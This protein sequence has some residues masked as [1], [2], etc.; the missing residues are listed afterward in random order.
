MLSKINFVIR[1]FQAV[2]TCQI[3]VVSKGPLKENRV[4][5][6]S[7]MCFVLQVAL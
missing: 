5:M 1:M 4:F 2:K 7:M 6:L 3:H